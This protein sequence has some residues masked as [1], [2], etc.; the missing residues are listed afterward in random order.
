[1]LGTSKLGRRLY[2]REVSDFLS[3]GQLKITKQELTNL[4]DRIGKKEVIN[5]VSQL[6]TQRKI[7][8][9]LKKFS[10][11][12]PSSFWSNIEKDYHRLVE[13]QNYYLP[14]Y[15]K[16]NFNKVGFRDAGKIRQYIITT[17]PNDYFEVN[18]ITDLFTEA[19]RM[20]CHL[21]GQP[22]PITFFRC[23]KL[24]RQLIERFLLFPSIDQPIRAGK[25]A[26]YLLREAFY[27]Q[28]AECTQF[29]VT[30]AKFIYDYFG[31]KTGSD[32]LTVYDPFA[33]WG[34]RLLGAAASS[35]V[36][37]YLGTDPN[38]D[39]IS[40]HSEMISFLRKMKVVGSY[41]VEPIP[42]EEIDLKKSFP[43]GIDL[44]YSSPPFFNL[45]IYDQGKQS[46]QSYPGIKSWNRWFQ[47]I[48]KRMYQNLNQGGY[49]IYHLADPKGVSII[50]ELI[51]FM[52]TIGAVF[53][54]SIPFYSGPKKRPV[55]N[56]IWTNQGVGV[57]TGGSTN[58][59]RGS[60]NKSR[61]SRNKSRGSRNKSRGSRNKSRR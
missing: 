44:I 18:L 53:L 27:P 22:S 11:P 61:G 20:K 32:N 29:R 23:P 39:L 56:Y 34:D 2:N 10:L 1:M 58:K 46:I 52:E 54:G 26:T 3:N 6:I 36:N 30:L 24:H 14:Y 49:L 13:D 5:Q 48:T 16:K 51:S 7:K 57:T 21:A 50:S 31:M 41:S 33:G 15:L 42:A 60:R 47:Q 40:G 55:F 25:E 45:E 38:P 28:V 12:G 17:D 8:F 19:A 37:R 4:I 9:P 59:S 43:K 35:V